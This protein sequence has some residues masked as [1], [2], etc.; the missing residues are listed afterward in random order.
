MVA[1]DPR[2]P[3]GGVKRSGDGRELGEWGL[4]EFVNVKTVSIAPGTAGAGSGRS[5]RG[6]TGSH[7]K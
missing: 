3:F 2:L 6:G 5:W 7:G 1:S 4:R